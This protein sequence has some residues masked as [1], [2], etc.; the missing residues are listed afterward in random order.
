MVPS[1]YVPVSRALYNNLPLVSLPVQPV[2]GCFPPMQTLFSL[3]LQAP[4]T[5]F[6]PS[7][8]GDTVPSQEGF[9]YHHKPLVSFL[10]QIVFLCGPARKVEIYP[11]L[12]HTLR[13]QPDPR[14]TMRPQVD[15]TLHVADPV[16]NAAPPVQAS[17]HAQQLARQEE[18]IQKARCFLQERQHKQQLERQRLQIQQ[19]SRQLQQRQAMRL[20]QSMQPMGGP[21]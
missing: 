9:S 1:A 6:E 21:Q 7:S 18:Q 3:H 13:F 17:Q 10:A 12:P 16:R 11:V 5:A 14:G 4:G 8:P 15:Y 2:L 19:A 20:M